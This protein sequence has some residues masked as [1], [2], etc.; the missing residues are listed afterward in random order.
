MLIR[1]AAA[2][3]LPTVGRMNALRAA[4]VLPLLLAGCAMPVRESPLRE[5][6]DPI[7]SLQWRSFVDEKLRGQV[8]LG[9]LTGADP[10]AVG[11]LQKTLERLWDSRAASKLLRDAVEEQ[12]QEL[13]LLANAALPARYLLD[14]EILSLAGGSLPLA[15]EGEVE[16]RYRLREIDGGRVVYERRL[17]SQGALGYGL[18]WPPARQRA[19]KEAALRANLLKLGQELVRL[20]V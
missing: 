3:A 7:T 14:V 19:A 6:L 9:E 10:E 13:R 2:A 8:R 17:R 15:S 16:V 11:Y 4:V 20:R 1:A 5:G 12:L 18:L